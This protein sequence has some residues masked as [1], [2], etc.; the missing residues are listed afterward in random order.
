MSVTVREP[1]S[2]SVGKK[3]RPLWMELLLVVGIAL[4]LAVIIKTFLAQA[5]Y[6]PSESMEKTLMPND[7]IIVEKVSSWTGGEPQ[8]GD[9]VVF[10]DPGGWLN[11]TQVRTATGPMAKAL[12]A[13]GLYPTGGHLVKRVIGVGGDTVRCCDAK[14]RMEVNGTPLNEG[15]LAP[16]DKPSLVPFTINVPKGYIWVQGDHRSDSEDSR[17]HRGGPAGGAVPVDDVVGRVVA[18]VWPW[19][20]A[21]TFPRP[22]TY[23]ALDR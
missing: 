19:G 8:R 15:Y 20:H 13:I 10:K 5:F 16:G 18:L 1:Q 23:A 4:V 7:R 21:R 17:Y 11:P 14:G 2:T 22:A 9:I 6:V 12:E 3:Q